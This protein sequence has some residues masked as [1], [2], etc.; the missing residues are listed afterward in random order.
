M[1][2]PRTGIPAGDLTHALQYLVTKVKLVEIETTARQ[3]SELSSLQLNGTKTKQLITLNQWCEQ[4]LSSDQWASL[5]T[6][7]RKRRQR[8]SNDDITITISRQAHAKLTE[9]A[10]RDRVTL[11][12]A[13]ERN[14]RTGTGRR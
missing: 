1:S 3:R 7:I 5:K 12:Q 4:V 2:R 8:K 11:S 10:K 14:L 13:I 9:I 6:A